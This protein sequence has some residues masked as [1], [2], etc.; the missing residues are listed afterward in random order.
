MAWPIHWGGAALYSKMTTNTI[1]RKTH[2]ATPGGKRERSNAM[3]AAVAVDAVTLRS[4]ASSTVVHSGSSHPP[5][6]GIRLTDMTL[7]SR[8]SNIHTQ[9]RVT[10]LRT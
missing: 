1:A 7:T 4:A 8:I 10:A 2:L 5:L 9:A 3:R 6:H